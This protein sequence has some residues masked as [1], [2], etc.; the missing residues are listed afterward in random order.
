MRT[1]DILCHKNVLFAPKTNDLKFNHTL[2]STW[3]QEGKHLILIYMRIALIYVFKIIS[4]FIHTST[5]THIWT[6][7][8][9]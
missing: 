2:I 8:V 9:M 5:D 1:C 3:N 4:I 7:N 6:R